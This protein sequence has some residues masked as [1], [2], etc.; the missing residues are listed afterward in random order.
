MKRAAFIAAYQ[1]A[2]GEAARERITQRHG[3]CDEQIYQIASRIA[4]LR[5]WRAH[6]RTLARYTVAEVFPPLRAFDGI[7]ERLWEHSQPKTG[8]KPGKTHKKER[9]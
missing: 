7:M 3:R 9:K 6:Y 2:T 5:F 1:Q 4:A 8:G